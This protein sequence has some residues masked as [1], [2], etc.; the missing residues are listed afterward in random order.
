MI[1]AFCSHAALLDAGRILVSGPGKVA[2]TRYRQMILEGEA[3][4]KR[5]MEIIEQLRSGDHQYT[6]S[7]CGRSTG[8][9]RCLPERQ[10]HL[11]RPPCRD[12]ASARGLNA[13]TQRRP[14]GL[15]PLSCSLVLGRDIPCLETGVYRFRFRFLPMPGT[16][17][18]WVT[19]TGD[20][21]LDIL[22]E[23]ASKLSNSP[24]A[25][26]R[27]NVLEATARRGHVCFRLLASE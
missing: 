6:T 17:T 14:D 18:A 20:T 26:R 3:T 4:P 25:R 19:I 8:R 10:G 5:A 15:I 12:A 7:R 11:S 1:E 9:I 2:T 23:A 13:P 22:D 27:P 21:K 16:Y 24:P